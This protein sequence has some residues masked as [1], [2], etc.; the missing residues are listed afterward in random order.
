MKNKLKVCLTKLQMDN[1]ISLS[2]QVQEA[3][4]E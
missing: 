3:E 2:K 1:P 4:E